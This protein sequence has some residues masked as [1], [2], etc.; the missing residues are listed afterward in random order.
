MS[1]TQVIVNVSPQLLSAE[2]V[3]GAEEG[4]AGESQV[5]VQ[6]EHTYWDEVRVTQVVDEAADV[7]IV[8]GVNTIHLPILYRKHK[9]KDVHRVRKPS[10]FTHI[11]HTKQ[12]LIS[13][14]QVYCNTLVLII[15]FILTL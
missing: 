15:L 2:D 9:N 1:S 5:L 11:V 10:L 8:A 13:D 6:H 4:D 3:S 12:I 7:A 14:W